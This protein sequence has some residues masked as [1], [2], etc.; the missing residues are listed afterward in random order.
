[1]IIPYA[2][3]GKRIG[4]F[5]L[6]RTGLAAVH[7]LQAAG[8]QVLAWDDDAGRLSGIEDVATNLY[9]ETFS[10][11]DALMLAPG[12]PLTHPQPHP[13][14]VKATDA[15]IQVIGDTELF[16]V[17]RADLP[18]HKL[19]AVT[20]TNGKSTTSA[21]LAHMWDMCRH[22][23]VLGG[24]I[25]VP[26]LGLEPL[27]AGGIYV[28]ELSSFQIDLTHSLGADVA[29]LLNL[30]PDHLDRHGDMAGYIAA[31]RRLFSMQSETDVAII[32]VDDEPGRAIAHS[33]GARA[34][35]LSVTR[36]LDRG[37]YVESDGRLVDSRDGM[38]RPVGSLAGIASLR[39]RHNWQNA[40]AAY[41]AGI[42]LGL[43]ADAIL[44]AFQSFPG[45]HHR[46]EYLGS[47]NDVH[48]VN[49]SKATNIDAAATALAAY[50]AIRW[51]AGGRAK[52]TDLGPLAPY[53][54]HIRHAYL[55][56]ED[57]EN[58]AAALKG[59]VATT[60]CGTVDVATHAAHR[61]AQPGETVLFSPA[62]ASFDQFPDFEARGDAFRNAASIILEGCC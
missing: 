27:K 20:G 35:P 10:D 30:T 60:Q 40:A 26:I 57:S 39:G 7:A 51:I 16:A 42:S 56:G 15:G 17:A 48:F 37:I 44:T 36:P 18:A 2:Y 12:V 19:V 47:R 9:E 50:D 52:S 45:L 5:G 32:G 6:A 41:G 53:F 3:K 55:I 62:C 34:I 46:C 4:V 28:F 23:V 38:K 24:N 29:I 25:G 33:L 49:D 22:P 21:L 59:K 54:P 11:L 61:D 8:A 14:V 1:M 31:K 13:L 58:F 43:A